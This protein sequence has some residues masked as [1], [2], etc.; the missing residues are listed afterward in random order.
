M[1]ISK[2]WGKQTLTAQDVSK[3]LKCGKN[4]AY[5]LMENGEMHSVKIGI[6]IRISMDSFQKWIDNQ[7]FTL[8]KTRNFENQVYTIEEIREILNIG[9]NAA[10]SLL[11][12]HYFQTIRIGKSI[13][14]SKKSFDEWLQ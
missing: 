4:M 2:D 10:Y 14:I 1:N 11:N 8:D 6:L 13:R 3:I 9:K 12:H 5:K 7:N